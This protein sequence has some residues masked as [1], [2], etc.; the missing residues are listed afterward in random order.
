MLRSNCRIDTYNLSNSIVYE[1]RRPKALVTYSYLYL[2]LLFFLHIGDEHYFGKMIQQKM[3]VNFT[4]FKTEYTQQ[5]LL[6]RHT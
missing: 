2:Y 1:G 5:S 4:D 3:R 6:N